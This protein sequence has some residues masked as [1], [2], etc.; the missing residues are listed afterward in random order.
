M[1]RSWCALA[2]AVGLLLG[3]STVA[4]AQKRGGVLTVWLPDS[5][6]GLSIHEEATV[7]SMGP[8]AGVFDNLIVFDQHVKQSSLDTI[9]P[10]LA[11]QWSWS[12]DGLALTFQLRHGVKFHDGQPFTA[13]DVLC[14]WA[15]LLETSAAKI[16]RAHV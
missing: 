5:P 12:G 10:D 8:M 2:V 11:T 13:Q 9:L 1:K 7:M 16:G 3:L 14:T 15:L 4:L 6:G